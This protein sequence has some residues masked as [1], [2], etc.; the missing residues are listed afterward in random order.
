V[1]PPADVDVRAIE[2][3]SRS[4]AGFER[5]PQQIAVLLSWPVT[6]ERGD[7]FSPTVTLSLSSEAAR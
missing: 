5:T 3:V 6:L 2:T 1:S 7:E 4:E